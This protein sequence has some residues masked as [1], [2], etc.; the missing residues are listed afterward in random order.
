[1]LPALSLMGAGTLRK[2][3]VHVPPTK[4]MNTNEAQDQGLILTYGMRYSLIGALG[5]VT[6]DEDTDAIVPEDVTTITDTQAA[7]LQAATR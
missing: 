6:A 7:D 3:A 1:M 2:P 4:G 5:I